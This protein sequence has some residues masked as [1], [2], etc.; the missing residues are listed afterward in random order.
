MKQKRTFVT[1]LLILAI[2]CL[3]IAYA[4]ITSQ[5]LTI[6]GSATAL[7]ENKPVNVIF[8]EYA[9]QPGYDGKVEASIESDILAKINVSE[10]TTE[11][12]TATVDYTIEN[13]AT[14]MAAT[15]DTPV[16][17]FDAIDGTVV[18]SEWFDVKCTLS[19]NNLTANNETLDSTTASAK[20]TVT[21]TLKKTPVTQE[22]QAAAAEDIY[23]KI[24]AN[25]VSNAD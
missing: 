9:I 25:P 8:T 4:A 2:L 15:L 18:E 7:A 11:G 3:G 12:D 17:T 13:Q 23:V 22:D 1:L 14:D 5:T 6:T 19:G 20:A 10:L 16:V 24:V 21:V